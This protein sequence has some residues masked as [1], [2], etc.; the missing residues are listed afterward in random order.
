M[1][2]C[3]GVSINNTYIVTKHFKLYYFVK[4]LPIL[5]YTFFR[6]K[7][8]QEL[9]TLHIFSSL[10]RFKQRM[11]AFTSSINL[12][13]IVYI[14][15][16]LLSNNID[17]WT[18]SNRLSICRHP[19]LNCKKFGQLRFCFKIRILQNIFLRHHFFHKFCNARSNRS[20]IQFPI[21]VIKNTRKLT[22]ISHRIFPKLHLAWLYRVIS[23]WFL[24]KV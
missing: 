13:I 7:L 23:I 21:L 17:S 15:I 4:E 2:V 9:Y 22:N 20:V 5:F 16:V 10:L 14:L 18:P 3:V 24:R 12:Y 6:T 1:Y 19:M 8:N 11:N